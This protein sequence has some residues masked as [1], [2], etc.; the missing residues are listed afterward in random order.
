M[1]MIN[2]DTLRLKVFTGELSKLAAES[3]EFMTEKEKA[4]EK[5]APNCKIITPQWLKWLKLPFYTF[6]TIELY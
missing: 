5:I 4:S 2:I 1:I 3:S 6:D